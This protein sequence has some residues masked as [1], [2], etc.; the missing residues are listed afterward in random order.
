MS[1]AGPRSVEGGEFLIV[2]VVQKPHGIRGELAVRL[3]TDRPEQVFRPERRLRVGDAQGNPTADELTV[4]RARPFKGGLLVKVREFDG[5]NEAIE[6]MRG[7]TLLLPREETA[8][9]DTD[10]VWIHQLPGLRVESDGATVGSVS[11]VFD[12]ATGHLLEVATPDGRELLVPFVRQIVVRVDPAAGV[13]EIDAPP[14][15][16]EL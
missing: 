16:L 12:T 10:E 7:R 6:A 5:R 8:P 11:E 9:L 4:E 3:E 14:G 13:L 1:A 2:G 15:L